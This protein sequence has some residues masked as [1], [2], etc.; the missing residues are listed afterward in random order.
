MIK[1]VIFDMG[2]VIVDIAPFMEQVSHVFEPENEKEFWEKINVEATS[3]C[4]GEMTLVQFWRSVAQ[5]CGKDIPDYV[6]RDLWVIDGEPSLQESIPD[7]IRSLK[8]QY[9]LG[10][11]SNTMKEHEVKRKGIFELFDV[12]VLSYEVGLTKEDEEIFLLAADRL[13]VHPAECVFIDDIMRF[14][15]VA[16]S[17]G[18]KGILFEDTEQLK[19]DLRTWGIED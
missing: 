10:I 2:G 5:K 3:L 12:I 14:V 11:I 18:M 19:T 4:K 6:L 1:A 16:Q 8:N 17:V 13:G 9:K 15:E 7:I